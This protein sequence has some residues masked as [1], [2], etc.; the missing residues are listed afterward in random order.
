MGGTLDPCAE[1]IRD[2]L[3]TPLGAMWSSTPGR[4]KQLGGEWACVVPLVQGDGPDHGKHGKSLAITRTRFFPTGNKGF[5]TGTITGTITDKPQ[6][7]AMT[8]NFT[9][10]ITGSHQSRVIAQAQSR[11]SPITTLEGNCLK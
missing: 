5:F 1:A 6:S 2:L 9:G 11:A 8:G 10:T 3:C 7:R 4:S